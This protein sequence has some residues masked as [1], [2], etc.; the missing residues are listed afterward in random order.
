MNWRR[1]RPLT[2]VI[3][4]VAALAGAMLARMVSHPTVPLAGGTW[5]PEARTL[6]AFEIQDLLGKPFN[7][8]SLKGHPHL[9][10]FGFTYCPDICPTTLA[11]LSQVLPAGAPAVLP[12]ARVLFISIDPER[13]SAANLQDYLRAFSN[14]IEGARPANVA[15]LTPLLTSLGAI[16]SR[17][18]L[19]DGSYTL[20]HTAAIYLLDSR[21]RYRAVFTPPISVAQL[22]GDL[23]RIADAGV[24]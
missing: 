19:P 24:L 20:D 18:S 9:L 1:P 16:A 6:A 14:G 8:A 12:D 5:L 23:Q 21:G 7:N 15:A 11:T 13:D 22:K 10:F 3:G 4:L 17:V 2:L